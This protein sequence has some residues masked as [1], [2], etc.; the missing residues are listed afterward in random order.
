CI[1]LT[2]DFAIGLWHLTKR[3]ARV[4][5]AR[6]DVVPVEITN[7]HLFVSKPKIASGSPESQAIA[8]AGN[9]N[10]TAAAMHTPLISNVDTET[11]ASKVPSSAAPGAAAP[12]KP[13]SVFVS[14]K[15]NR[16]FVRQGFTPLF[17]VPVNIQ[18]PEQPLGTHVFTVME[19]ENEDSAVRWSVVS[20]PEEST[21]ADSTKGSKASKQ[22]I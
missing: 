14:R 1:R 2:N 8:V 22:Q 3:G 9:G 20:I 10:M 12:Q 13:I 6:E 4:I 18:N 21:A 7:S 11:A 17:D 15:F 5:I 19:P 16:L